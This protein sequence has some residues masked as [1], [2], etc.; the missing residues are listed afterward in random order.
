MLKQVHALVC[1]GDHR[2]HNQGVEHHGHQA[3]QRAVCQRM[4]P[5]AESG[6]K[7]GGGQ[8]GQRPE[9]NVENVSRQQVSHSAA[10]KQ[11][12][13][14]TRH[15][16]GQDA[17]DFGNT[18]L[19]RSVADG[20]QGHGQHRIGGAY[21]GGGGKG[22]CAQGF[23]IHFLETSIFYLSQGVE[24]CKPVQKAKAFRTGFLPS[25]FSQ[26]KTL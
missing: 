20:G 21:N 4:L 9:N 12:P 22:V 8:S 23:V 14:R 26:R 1:G 17:K 24:T 3:G 16:I 5:P 25:L 11:S 7:Q 15:K 2:A 6:G 10:D 19:D 18:E 13:R